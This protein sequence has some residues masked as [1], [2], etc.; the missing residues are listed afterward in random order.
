MS[1]TIGTLLYPLGFAADALDSATETLTGARTWAV[2]DGFVGLI[3]CGGTSRTLT[4]PA[5]ASAKSGVF[6]FKNVSNGEELLTIVD[7]AAGGV[8]TLTPNGYAVLYCNGSSWVVLHRFFGSQIV[9]F[10]KSRTLSDDLTLAMT[11]A[12]IQIL[13]P[14]GAGRNVTLP[15][16]DAAIGVVWVIVNAA[17]AAES[18]TVKDDAGSTVQTVAQNFIG[19]FISNGAAWGSF[20]LAQT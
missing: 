7:D 2:S 8:T 11:D 4:L 16:E 5:E 6:F 18:L 14:G 19:I 15:A 12:S 3:D 9:A 1:N 13:D 17:D 10:H 20:K